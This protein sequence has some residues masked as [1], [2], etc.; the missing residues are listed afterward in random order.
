MKIW[1]LC[2]IYS[3]LYYMSAI[4]MSSPQQLTFYLKLPTKAHETKMHLNALKCHLFCI[5]FQILVYIRRQSSVLDRPNIMTHL[6]PLGALIPTPGGSH[7]KCTCEY[8]LKNYHCVL[9]LALQ[10]IPLAGKDSLTC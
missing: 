9:I 1:Q 10:P 2:K 7:I 6:S 8:T 3:T 5:Y 4:S